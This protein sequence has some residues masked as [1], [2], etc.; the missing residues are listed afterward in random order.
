MDILSTLRARIETIEAG[1]HSIGLA[2]VLVH[3]ETATRHLERGRT[4]RDESAYTDAV[5]RT[6]QAFEGS[7]K[8]AYRV[9]AGKPPDRKTPHEIE[10]YLEKNKVLHKRVLVLFTHYRTDWRNASAHDYTLSFNESEA[11]IAIVSVTAFATVLTDQIAERIAFLRAQTDPTLEAFKVALLAG[12]KSEPLVWQVAHAVAQIGSMLSRDKH[13]PVLSEAQTIGAIAGLLS[14]GE[15]GYAVSVEENLATNLRMQP[16]MVVRSNGEGIVVEI[17][18]TL[19]SSAAIESAVNQIEQY[20]AAGRLE[21]GLVFFAASNPASYDL[22]AHERKA[23]RGLVIAVVPR[24][25]V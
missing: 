11:Y 17:K 20:L 13:L 23:G 16:D 10:Q 4:F 2:A 8:E 12:R 5:Y 19:P 14:S 22:H 1:E 9:L 24:D 3:V 15:R 21:N 7:I 6:N 25:D 18:R